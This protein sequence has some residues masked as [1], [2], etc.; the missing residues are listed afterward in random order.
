MLNYIFNMLIDFPLPNA[1]DAWNDWWFPNTVNVRKN[2]DA[3]SAKCVTHV[4][5]GFNELL[6]V[7]GK[8]TFGV[9][10]TT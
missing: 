7:F 3:S 4:M 9:T 5:V 6:C 2:S 10:L 8:S 1:F